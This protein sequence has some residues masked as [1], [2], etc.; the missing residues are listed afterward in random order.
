MLRFLHY[1]RVIVSIVFSIFVIFGYGYFSYQGKKLDILKSVDAK[2]ISS[3]IA[4]QVIMSDNFVD[5]AKKLNS[6]SKKEDMANIISLSK[7]AKASSVKYVY[8]MN[9]DKNQTIHFLASSGTDEEIATGKKLTRYYDIYEPNPYIIQAIKTHQVVYQDFTQDAWGNFRSIYVPYTTSMGNEYLIG[10]D[11]DLAEIQSMSFNAALHEVYGALLILLSLSPILYLLKMFK[12]DNSLL[13]EKINEATE[14]LKT[15]NLHLQEQ[16]D[17]KTHEL[18]E[19]F[20]HDSLTNLPNRDKLKEDF[21]MQ[22]I[23]AIAIINIDDFKEIND[24]FGIKA[25]DNILIQFS[26]FLLKYHKMTY[27]LG[28]DEF[29]LI[30]DN[31]FTF[32]MIKKDLETLIIKI[33]NEPLILDDQTINIRPS[34]GYAIG[35]NANLISADMA[36]HQA[37]ER[38]IPLS[39]FTEDEQIQSN[40]ENNI[41]MANTI[42]YAVANEKII[43]HYQPIMSFET[44]ALTKYETLVRLNTKEN[45]I[46]YPNDFLKLSQKTKH[47]PYITQ[48]VVQQACDFF[49]NRS[50]SFSINLSISDITNPSTV[51]FIINTLQKTQTAR[52]VVFEILESEGIENFNIVSRFIEQVKSMGAK[53][54]IDD[55]G[56]GY[57]SFENILKLNID[58]IKIDGSLIKNIDTEEKHAIVVETIID[59]AKKIHVKTIAEYVCNEAVCAKCKELGID[60]AQGFYIGKPDKL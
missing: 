9:V 55:F 6:I 33:E 21:Q 59:F 56:T 14:E 24:F 43:C 7:F 28:S 44:N 13:Q 36:L 47:Y 30:Y 1:H 39:L 26:N 32:D 12:K 58:Y 4:T 54:A 35:S 23:Y 22:A 11:I 53:I 8:L 45:K 46:V 20:Y 51:S 37:K 19:Q 52:R 41:K 3:A 49:A 5:R 15:I 60:Y 40:Y 16:V 10:V 2:L 57:S 38:K 50:E 42:K 48:S 17:D 29:A 27:R 34:I 18:I 31:T 25:G